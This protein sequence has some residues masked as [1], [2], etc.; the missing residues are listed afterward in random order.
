[1]NEISPLDKVPPA[2][3]AQNSSQVA[4]HNHFLQTYKR[5]AQKVADAIESSISLGARHAVIELKDMDT[6]TGFKNLLTD[7]VS[8]SMKSVTEELEKKDYKVESNLY[9]MTIRW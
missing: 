5:V 7:Y 2:A 4:S 1:M 3:D 9:T 8:K 6:A